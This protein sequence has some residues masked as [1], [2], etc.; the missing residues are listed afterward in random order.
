MVPG[1][2]CYS[3][4]GRI[5]WKL[6]AESGVRFMWAKC[7][8][9]NEPR[10]DDA[11]YRYNVQAAR[12]NGVSVGAYFYA[13]PLPSGKDKPAG[14]DPLSQAQRFFSLTAGLGGQAGELSPA[15]D[16]EWPP[17]FEK[18]KGA[19]GKYV[20][21][22]DGSLKLVD[23]W[24][25]W[26]CSAQQLSDWGH[27]F[28]EAVTV[29]FGRPPIVYTYPW[30]WEAVARGAD[31]SWA[32]KYPL[33]L[34]SYVH[35]GPGLPEPRELPRALHPWDQWDVL[36]YS[37]DGSSVRVPGVPVSPLDRNCMRDESALLRLTGRAPTVDPD[38]DT[39]P[40]LRPPVEPPPDRPRADGSIVDW[41]IVRSRFY[42]DDGS[43]PPP[44]AA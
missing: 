23:K 11:L 15:F 16:L 38:A 41:A 24:A 2:D 44:D 1:I 40:S 3:G 22:P 5:N 34:A 21:N 32:A 8:E 36:Q 4:Y 27:D 25:E 29:L 19:D 10:R 6:V 13:Y 43:D 28:C 18:V 39:K 14:R 33:W 37:A 31:V 30:W 12:D 20:F 42:R 17:P 26:G 9:G 7:G 35:L